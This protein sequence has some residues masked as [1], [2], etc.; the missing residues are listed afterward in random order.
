M[1]NSL[2]HN[3]MMCQT[4]QGEQNIFQRQT[5][6]F[7][8]IDLEPTSGP[9]TA[10]YTNNRHDQFK[11]FPFGLKIL[12]NSRILTITLVL[13]RQCLA[14]HFL[15]N[16]QNCYFQ[17]FQPS[18]SRKPDVIPSDTLVDILFAKPMQGCVISKVKNSQP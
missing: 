2:Y 14:A 1:T 18:F 8:Q 12:S 4:R 17:G 11:R 9:P 13:T 5:S 7:H 10:F 3:Q 16:V 15:K 6:S